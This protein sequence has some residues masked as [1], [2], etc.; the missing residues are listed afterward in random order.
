[1]TG[2]TPIP[3]WRKRR[4]RL[5][6]RLAANEPGF[7]VGL[8]IAWTPLVE[9]VGAAGADAAFIDMEHTTLSLEDVENLIVGCEAAG[10]ASIVRVAGLDLSSASRALDSG[11]NGVM[12]PDIR[13]ADS[14]R[15][16]V[17]AAKYPPAGRR[18]WGGA[19]TRS[20]MWEGVLATRALTETDPALRGIYSPEFVAFANG[21]SLVVILIESPDGVANLDEILDVDGIDA[22]WF[23]MAD[24][25]A[26]A[27]FD[28][29]KCIS[30]GQTV[31]DACR[32]RGIGMVLALDQLETQPWY[33]GCF[34][35]A[36]LDTLIL[37]GAIRSAV[38]NARQRVEERRRT[39]ESTEKGA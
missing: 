6:E 19:H 33:P 9:I 23:G 7:M 16:A 27:G 14:A 20:V 25:S 12:Y 5:Q 17:A 18:P 3:Y 22:V 10:I 38:A 36:G 1:M 39:V 11:A 8:D 35:L 31:Y 15:R 34:F 21:Q 28:L 2:E 26:Q 29:D 32:A 30:A 37:S 4:N 13:D 24:Y